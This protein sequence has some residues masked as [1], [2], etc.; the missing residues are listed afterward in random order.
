M[1]VAGFDPFQGNPSMRWQALTR[2]RVSHVRT[3]PRALR[4]LVVEDEL[5][6][7]DELIGLVRR[8]GHAARLA[9]DGRAALQ[10]AAEEYP[11]VVL[12]DMNVPL[13]DGCQVARQLRLNC[14]G[15]E[16]FI[17]AT[18]GQADDARRQQCIESGIDLLFV[19]PVD[20]VLVETLLLLEYELVN[21][22]WTDNDLPTK[23]SSQFTHEGDKRESGFQ[24]T[25]TRLW[26]ALGGGNY[27]RSC[28]ETGG[29]SC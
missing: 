27:R 8:W 7:A 22:S 15:K 4:V 24:T 1:K 13:M 12:M 6:A 28:Y 19:K 11:D 9:R 10:V 25:H 21:R 14:P 18:T 3:R 17:I 26:Q 23:A 5:D 20:A 2:D 29:F 16:C